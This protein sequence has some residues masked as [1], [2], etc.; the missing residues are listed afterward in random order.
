MTYM[1]TKMFIPHP[2]TAGY[3]DILLTKAVFAA[4]GGKRTA[5][6]TGHKDS[7][8]LDILEIAAKWD[9]RVKVQDVGELILEISRL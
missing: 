1:P 7:T 8:I 4:A 2:R 6:V 9:L 5:I 3:F